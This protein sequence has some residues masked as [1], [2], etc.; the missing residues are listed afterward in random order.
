MEWIVGLFVVLLVGGIWA[1]VSANRKASQMEDEVRNLADF[2]AA[3]VYVSPHNHAG[4]AIDRNRHEILLT[5][6]KDT[7]IFRVESIISCEVLED[8][9][10]LAYANRGSQML[11][12]AVGGALLGGVGAVVGGLSGSQRTMQRVQSVVLRFTTDDFDNPVHDIV[13]AIATS[14]KGMGKD[15]LV[16]QEALK[17]AQ[18]WHARTVA[19]MRAAS[20]E[21]A[22]K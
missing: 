6:K 14:K 16:Y 21:V 22:P 20:P 7:R 19:M 8:G 17:L 9:V 2:D 13:V 1:G 3:D 11:G 4:V 12:V 10:Q 15:G 5:D 18:K